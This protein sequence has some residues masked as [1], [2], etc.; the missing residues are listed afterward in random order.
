MDDFCDLN[1]GRA[2]G[3]SGPDDSWATNSSGEGRVDD[4]VLPGFQRA[5]DGVYYPIDDPDD[6][7]AERERDLVPRFA[8][9][10]LTAADSEGMNYAAE[11]L[12]LPARLEQRRRDAT[13]R[14]TRAQAESLQDTFLASDDV[15]GSS[16]DSPPSQEESPFILPPENSHRVAVEFRTVV[17][18]LLTSAVWLESVALS[19]ISPADQERLFDLSRMV[20]QAVARFPQAQEQLVAIHSSP[21]F[22]SAEGGATPSGSAGPS[23]GPATSN[24][25]SLSSNQRRR[26][27][28]RPRRR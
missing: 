24:E 22:A 21:P 19:T 18:M 4:L 3:N 17:H 26:P 16:L 10:A 1:T 28:R 23:E 5:D 15:A 2:A 27:Q 7:P 12:G 20:L 8:A 11:L 9:A 6:T 14:Q 25:A 13:I